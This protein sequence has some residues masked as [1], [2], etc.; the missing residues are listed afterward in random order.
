MGPTTTCIAASFP[1]LPDQLRT[2]GVCDEGDGTTAPAGPSALTAAGGR[3]SGG[4]H[5]A[6]RTVMSSMPRPI[7][8][9]SSHAFN[10][11]AIR[12]RRTR[13][14][15]IPQTRTL[16]SASDHQS[17]LYLNETYKLI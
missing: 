17:H 11:P 10:S 2:S 9:A 1:Q 14:C 6:I 12:S 13:L 8:I 3:G 4:R 7:A 5:L 15:F 16:P